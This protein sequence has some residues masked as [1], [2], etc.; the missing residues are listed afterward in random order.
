M[1]VILPHLDARAQ[2]K[3]RAQTH[4]SAL[5]RDDSGLAWFLVDPDGVAEQ[6]EPAG[7]L[8]VAKK[9]VELTDR[10]SRDQRRC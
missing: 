8:P 3:V 10:Y 6:G 2:R 4:A 9:A 1:L 5:A 7:A